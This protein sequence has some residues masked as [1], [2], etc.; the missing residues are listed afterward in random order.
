[1]LRAEGHHGCDPH[2]E[3]P[4][5]SVD[6]LVGQCL[7]QFC[8][9]AQLHH[10]SSSGVQR[11]EASYLCAFQPVG[12]WLRGCGSPDRAHR[13]VVG[14]VA[15]LFW[16]LVSRMSVSSPLGSKCLRTALVVVVFFNDMIKFCCGCYEFTRGRSQCWP[17]IFFISKGY[18]NKATHRYFYKH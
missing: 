4:C 2:V 7:A 1:M 9:F 10:Q 5:G 16:L 11:A 13:L 18:K 12:G 15:F 14:L 3:G 17:L 6:V 8:T